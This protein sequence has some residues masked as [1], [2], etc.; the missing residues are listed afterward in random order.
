MQTESVSEVKVPEN[1]RAIPKL[2]AK[3]RWIGMEQEAEQLSILLA[4]VAPQEC[5]SIGPRETD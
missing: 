2:I 3:L 4:R 5:R 1:P